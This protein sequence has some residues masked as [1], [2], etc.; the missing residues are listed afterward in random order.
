[1]CLS[2]LKGQAT[3]HHTVAVVHAETNDLV[4][5]HAWVPGWPCHCTPWSALCMRCY[6][7]LHLLT[8]YPNRIQCAGIDTNMPLSQPI[9]IRLTTAQQHW[10]DVWRGDRMSRGTAI[11]LLLQQ[12]IDLHGRGL[13]PATGR[14]ES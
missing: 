6:K 1:M 8:L 13:L 5:G 2:L 3:L 10:L 9:A 4:S 11:R 7:M 14:R 12:S